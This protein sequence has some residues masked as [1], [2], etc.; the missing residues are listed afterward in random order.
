MSKTREIA[1][2]GNV[3]DSVSA[4]LASNDPARGAGSIWTAVGS[5]GEF[6]YKEVASSGNLGQTNAA[7]VEFDAVPNNAG[8]VTAIQMG[9]VSSNTDAANLTIIETALGLFN[10]V[11]VEEGISYDTAAFDGP[12]SGLLVDLNTG[13]M[14]FGNS[15]F[16]SAGSD[17]NA[18]R[19]PVAL[20]PLKDDSVAALWIMPSGV[21]DAGSAANAQTAAT[22]LFFD[23][24]IKSD[25]AGYRDFVRAAEQVGGY[26]NQGIALIA[27]KANGN[28][29]GAMP[30]LQLSF[31]GEANPYLRGMFM[32]PEELPAGTTSAFSGGLPDCDDGN[33]VWRAGMVV[34]ADGKTCFNNSCVYAATG[35]GTT[36]ATRPVHGQWSLKELVVADTS[37]LTVGDTIKG[38]T[39]GATGVINTIVNGT[40]FYLEN[41]NATSLADGWVT[42]E[43]LNFGDNTST[44]QTLV[45]QGD[46]TVSEDVAAGGK[47]PGPSV[48]GLVASDGGVSWEFIGYV[49]ANQPGNDGQWP[50]MMLGDE[51]AVP[52]VD[53][54]FPI[55]VKGKKILL[56]EDSRLSFG[57]SGA[58]TQLYEMYMDA[59]DGFKLIIESPTGGRVVFDNGA[60][61]MDGIVLAGSTVSKT[62][63]ATTQDADGLAILLCNDSTATSFTGFTGGLVGQRV[64]LRFQSG[65]TTLIDSTTLE[66][67]S[68]YNTVGNLNPV[69]GTAVSFVKTSGSRWTQV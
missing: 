41:E 56:T 35:A 23:S 57:R 14:A 46:A 66:V 27:P 26:G 30:E 54:N 13:A 9:C 24:L 2:L 17:S 34:T 52:E 69:P 37:G 59:N 16:M 10:G 1:N 31:Q 60:L 36:G 12:T 64:T 29:L 8:F 40:T 65:Q 63:G 3:Y 22:K 44:G 45:S 6:Y 18:Q 49:S 55:Q 5:D 48:A 50:L 51:T 53:R 11:I 21:P 61:R 33:S 38:A 7:S 25:G 4:L 15:G 19:A 43:T 67:K 68:G 28:A 62:S 39:S 58:L 47:P 42:S 32:I 20:M